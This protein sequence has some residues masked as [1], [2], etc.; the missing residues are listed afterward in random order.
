MNRFDGLLGRDRRA[1]GFLLDIGSLLGGAVIGA[2]V[3]GVLTLLFS[4]LNGESI[5]RAL[6]RRSETPRAITPL[7]DPAAER[8]A[9]GKAAARRLR[10]ELGLD[11][12]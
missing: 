12:R 3:G 8:I 9:E 1:A 7:S 11:Q 4:P 10:A 5:R 2:V 6:Q